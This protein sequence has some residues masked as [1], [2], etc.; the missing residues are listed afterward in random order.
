MSLDTN[1]IKVAGYYWYKNS[2]VPTARWEIVRVRKDS[3][4]LGFHVDFIDKK[5]F[6]TVTTS[7]LN[8]VPG[9]WSEPLRPPQ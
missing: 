4:G 6:E 1:D 5:T 7:R 9:D 8:E 3:A 2:S